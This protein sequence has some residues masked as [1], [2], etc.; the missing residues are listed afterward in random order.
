MPYTVDQGRSDKNT[1]NIPTFE[2]NLEPNGD[3]GSSYRYQ[4]EPGQI[5][6]R[7]IVDRHSTFRADHTV[8]GYFTT[9]LHGQYDSSDADL[10][11]TVIVAS[12]RFLSSSE[13]LRFRSASIE[14]VFQDHNDS[15]CG[16]EVCDVFPRGK[17]DLDPRTAQHQTNR[18][19]SAQAGATA[20]GGGNF[21]VTAGIEKGVGYE[22]RNQGSLVGSCKTS[23]RQWG[24]QN[25]ARWAMSENKVQK[26]GIPTNLEVAILLKR[27]GDYPF[28]A[29]ITVSASV[30]SLYGTTARSRKLWG[31][32]VIDPINFDP[33]TKSTGKALD[34]ISPENLSEFS[35]VM[36][37]VSS[38]TPTPFL[39]TAS[40]TARQVAS[41]PIHQT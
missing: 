36:K 2:I 26:N 4:N 20:I 10:K 32:D 29:A 13:E 28:R 16:P 12:F 1:D 25:T 40:R 23:G 11:A 3:P 35:R 15:K 27:Q 22:R 7:I 19:F 21:D 5:Q 14:F 24:P 9:V 6:R 33:Q 30:D 38:V 31:R 37:G 8:Q 41:S 39:K 18:N 17:I 34:D